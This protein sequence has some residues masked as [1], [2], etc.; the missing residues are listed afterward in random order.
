MTTDVEE[1]RR[2]RWESRAEVPLTLAALAFLAAYAVPILD[3]Q[4]PQRWFDLCVA[5]STIAWVLFA[6]D[7]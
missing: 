7:Y 3:P 1:A 2:H 6:V 4:L 5:V